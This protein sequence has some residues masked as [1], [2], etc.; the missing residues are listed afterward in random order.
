VGADL[1]LTTKSEPNPMLIEHGV[2]FVDL[3][4][5]HKI[6]V[7]GMTEHG[8]PKEYFLKVTERK[9]LVLV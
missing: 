1:M 3:E 8:A 6:R 2:L 9:G 7:L 4:N 5:P